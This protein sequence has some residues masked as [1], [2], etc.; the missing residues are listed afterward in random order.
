MDV[1]DDLEVE[2][3]RL[4]DLLS[5]LDDDQWAS[6]SAA[7]VNFALTAST[8]GVAALLCVLNSL[9]ALLAVSTRELQFFRSWLK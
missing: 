6:P 8:S 1:I 7:D 3:D 5:R 9:I 4:A 2:Q